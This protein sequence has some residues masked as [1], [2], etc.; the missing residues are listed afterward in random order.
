MRERYDAKVWENSRFAEG[1][2]DETT[3]EKGSEMTLL[4]SNSSLQCCPIRQKYLFRS[5]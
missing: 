1:M 5:T 4:P 3:R 2:G